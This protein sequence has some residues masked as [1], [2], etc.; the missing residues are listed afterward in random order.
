[1]PAS[2]TPRPTSDTAAVHAELYAAREDTDVQV[3][4]KEPGVKS[5]WF[6]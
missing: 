2:A 6:D 4:L 1:M 3:N 5:T